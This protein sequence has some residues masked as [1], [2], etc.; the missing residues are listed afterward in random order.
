MIQTKYGTHEQ[1]INTIKLIGWY[2]SFV[3]SDCKQAP[4]PGDIFNRT[5]TKD[6]AQRHLCDSVNR[7]I[8]TRA[9]LVISN[10]RDD[11]TGLKRDQWR[12]VDIHKRI[13]IYQ[14]ESRIIR[15]RFSHLLSNH[16]EN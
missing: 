5:M 2:K 16:N 14:F 10:S 13:R 15:K 11:L 7:S 1:V 12:L 3:N 8:N 6:E 9:G 4:I